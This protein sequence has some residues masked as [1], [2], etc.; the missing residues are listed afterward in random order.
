MASAVYRPEAPALAEKPKR[1]MATGVDVES[2]VQETREAERLAQSQND[3]REQSNLTQRVD[4]ERRQQRESVS[5]IES[6]LGEQLSTQRR[7]SDNLD[8]LVLFAES[9][10]QQD[11]NKSPAEYLVKRGYRPPQGRKEAFKPVVD[12]SS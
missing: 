1:V 11:T 4:K 10:F 7:M 5:R 9:K 2:D 12:L 8:K 3:Q 6:V